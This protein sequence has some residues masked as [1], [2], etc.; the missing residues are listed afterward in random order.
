MLPKRDTSSIGTLIGVIV[1][2]I[3]IGGSIF[4]NWEWSSFPNQPVPLA[5]GVL[6]AVA[7]L[8]VTVRNVRS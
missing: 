7:A 3:A 6:A 8:V 4:F 1:V 2:I 5:I